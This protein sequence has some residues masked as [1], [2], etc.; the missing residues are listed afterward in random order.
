MG[1]TRALVEAI[2]MFRRRGEVRDLS[3]HPQ[4]AV[5]EAGAPARSPALLYQLVLENQTPSY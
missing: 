2:E 4:G 1:R 5:V 3:H